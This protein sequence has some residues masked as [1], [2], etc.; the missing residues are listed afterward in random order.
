LF[1]QSLHLLFDGVPHDIDPEAVRV[2]L[3]T[4]DGVAE[5]HDLHIWAMG[6]SKVAL[7]AHLIVPMGY[8][9]GVFFKTAHRHLHD[10]FDISH[11][12]LQVTQVAVMDACHEHPSK[13]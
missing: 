4:L 10:A 6:T 12:T 3:G 5:V 9:D 8:P 7:T 11:A 1:N 2:Y 13:P